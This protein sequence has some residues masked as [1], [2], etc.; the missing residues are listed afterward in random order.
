MLALKNA[1]SSDIQCGNVQSS[2]NFDVPSYY[3]FNRSVSSFNE[4]TSVLMIGVNTR[5]ET[6]ILNTT[7][8]KHQLARDLTYV[9]LGV[10]A[11][12]KLKQNHL[13]ISAKNL[14]KILN[15]NVGTT[16]DLVLTKGSS[17]FLGS[18]IL[19]SKNGAVLQNLVRILGKNLFLKTP[20]GERLGILQG[21]STNLIFNHLGVAPGVRSTLNVPEISDKKYDL[22]YTVQPYQLSPKK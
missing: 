6:S 9:T 11:N 18:E 17:V 20:K 12:L 16:K 7:L 4:L 19:K 21:T 1:G 8:R 10:Y 2:I 13:G 14:L 3:T 5:F 15:N 22:L